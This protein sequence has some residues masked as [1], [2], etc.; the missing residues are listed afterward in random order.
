[1]NYTFTVTVQ[2]IVGFVNPL[3][4]AT[5]SERDE[6]NIKKQWL[7]KEFPS[8]SI[9]NNLHEIVDG[10]FPKKSA[11]INRGRKKAND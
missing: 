4:T 1:M 6:V 7:N 10:L 9:G 2:D 8:D 5:F 11:P 3:I